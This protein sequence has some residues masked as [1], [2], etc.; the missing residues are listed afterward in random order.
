MERV[1]ELYA[2]GDE[3]WQ[4]E[5]FLESDGL[6][7]YNE[8]ARKWKLWFEN[9]LNTRLESVKQNLNTLFSFT[10]M[11][12]ELNQPLKEAYAVYDKKDILRIIQDKIM[13]QNQ[14]DTQ[15]LLITMAAE[16]V[17]GDAGPW[18]KELWESIT[19]YPKA[20]STSLKILWR[21]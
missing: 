5:G 7:P 18:A 11:R 9:L 10:L 16:L 8:S 2:V 4:L 13:E 21:Y 15:R 14:D 1:V 6:N 19:E 12:K 20:S 3:I 17:G